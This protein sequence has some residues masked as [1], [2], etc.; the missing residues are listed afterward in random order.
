MHYNMNYED[1]SIEEL[2]DENIRLANQKDALRHQL[3]DLNPDD[4][5][6]VEQSAQIGAQVGEIRAELL[7]L[8]AVLNRKLIE[9]GAANPG[10]IVSVGTANANGKVNE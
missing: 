5:G 3:R 10:Q 7:R 4:E 6:F 9:Y 1:M 2:T 8:K